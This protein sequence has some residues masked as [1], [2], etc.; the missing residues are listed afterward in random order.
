MKIGNL[1]AVALFELKRVWNNRQLLIL[2]AI[3]PII[4]CVFFGFVTYKNP[5]AMSTTVFV[6]RPTFTE[7]NQET[8]KVIDEI[9]DYRRE[10]G[11][12][13][14][15]V[16]IEQNSRGDAIRQLDEGNT[17]AVIIFKQSQTGLE[18]IELII[19]VTETAVSNELNQVLPAILSK[20][21]KEISIK[22]LSEFL[23]EHR[24][25]VPEKANLEARQ[26]IAP[27][28][29]SV[30]TSAWTELRYFDFYASAMIMILTM[31]I[32]LS[33]SLITITSERARGTMERI[34]VTPYSS[35][36]I[37]GGKMLAFSV[38]AIVIAILVTATLKAV[39]NIA[40]GNIGLILL[41]TILVG[42][43]GVIFGLLISAITYSESESVLVGIL[44]IFAFMGLMTYMVPW[45]TMHEGAKL[46]S[47]ILPYTYA[48]QTIRNINMT[49]AGFSD[50]WPTFV[51]LAV[52]ILAQLSIAIPV[53]KREIK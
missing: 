43:N 18:S 14:F 42:I 22:N 23:V 53:L 45:E 34:F 17:R 4:S 8:R 48:I 24:G 50:V 44:C 33:L 29:I 39:F 27:Y 19:D 41:T 21:S 11:S 10:D 1:K 30:E 26:I 12:K 6:D 32:P 5:E 13:P 37:I 28:D 52:A 7:V 36:E 31:G 20:Y 16:I 38:L 15:S 49:G 51:I 35:A 25:L 9:N 47:Q 46:L 2:V 40:L 3:T